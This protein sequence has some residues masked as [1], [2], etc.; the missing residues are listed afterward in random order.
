MSGNTSFEAKT[1][2]QPESLRIV[3]TLCPFTVP[4]ARYLRGVVS[5]KEKLTFS[6]FLSEDILLKA[7]GFLGHRFL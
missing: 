7:R 4:L 2:E 5:D 1:H 6:A 3:E